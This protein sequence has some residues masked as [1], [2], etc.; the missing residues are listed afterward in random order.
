MKESAAPLDEPRLTGIHAATLCPL[1]RDGAVSEAEL[2]AHAG[3]I[4]RAEGI[5]GLLINGHAGEG[6]MMALDE[7]RRVTEVVREAVPDASFL[8]VGVTSESTA[9]AT[10]EAEDAARAGADAVLVFPPN[11][12]AMGADPGMIVDHHRAVAQACGL[13]VVL[14]K[15][16]LGW[17]RLS[18][19]VD[20]LARLCQIE[21][22]AGIKEGAWE[23]A[24]Y[25]ELRRR[26]K[27]ERPGVSVMASGDEH[28]FA[29][30]QIGTDGSQVSLAAIAPE[31]VTG[32][33]AACNAGDWA[34][35]R[36]LHEAIY[37]LSREIYRR[38]PAYLANARLKACLHLQ[39][40]IASDRMKRPM[41]EL[42]P[43]ETDRL[44]AVLN[45]ECE[46]A[47]A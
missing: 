17:G 28:L 32:L 42:T 7:R 9:A 44:R 46:R 25:E 38:A 14:Y 35:A 43:E 20:L 13:P 5:C 11:H 3:R 47:Q 36:E 27:A 18:Y 29:C 33:F 15:A 45:I 2:A 39:G 34:R 37:P 8:T 24:A 30:Y 19:D 12:W 16:P 21:A 26:I 31:L 23:V 22:V 41:R 10:R 40:H 4:A 6:G 1:T